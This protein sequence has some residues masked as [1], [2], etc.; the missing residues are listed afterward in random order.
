MTA[1]KALT[2]MNVGMQKEKSIDSKGSFN[3]GAFSLG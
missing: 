2:H 3:A 1:W